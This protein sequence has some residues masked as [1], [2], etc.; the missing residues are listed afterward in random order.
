MSQPTGT[1][2]NTRI[3]AVCFHVPP[4][5]FIARLRAMALRRGQYLQGVVV[6]N[7]PA[8]PLA[9]PSSDIEVIRGS[10]AHLD[11]SG[12]FEGLERLVEVR[13]DAAMSNVLFI[14]DSLI[15]KHAADCILH[16]VLSLDQLLAQ[17]AVPAICGKLDPYRSICLRNPW[18]GHTGYVSSYCFLLNA[19]AVPVMR[20]LPCNAVTDGVLTTSPLANRDWGVGMPPAMRESIRAHLL[21]E[22]SPYLWQSRETDDAEVALK[23][24]CCVYFESRLSGVIGCNGAVVPINAGPR[25]QA[26]IFVRETFARVARMLGGAQ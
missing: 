20:S 1:P 2:S 16:R 4:A 5:A 23:K 6:S 22:G 15:I 21:Y 10:N 7:N 25:S 18:S 26:D 19:L 11:F 3:V 17:L 12:Y 14:N 9:S 24:A 13:S 8:H